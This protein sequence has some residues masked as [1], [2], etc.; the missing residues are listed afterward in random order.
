[1]T[2]WAS[3]FHNPAT[4]I[5]KQEIVDGYLVSTVYIGLDHRFSDDGPPLIYE[6]MIFTPDGSPV[7]AYCERYHSRLAAKA[8]HERAVTRVKHLGADLMKEEPLSGLS[9]VAPEDEADE[10]RK[11]R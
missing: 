5:V 6:T 7:G 4:K 1:M 9:D 8:G 2:T 3:F 10:W 11:R